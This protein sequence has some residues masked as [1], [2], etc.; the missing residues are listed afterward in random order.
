MLLL[1]PLLIRTT[2][3]RANGTFVIMAK[4][5]LSLVPGWNLVSFNLHPSDTAISTVLSGIAGKYDLVYA[6]DAT[7][8][9]SASGNWMKYDPNPRHMEITFEQ[10]GREDGLLDSHEGRGYVGSGGGLPRQRR[11]CA[12]WIMGGW[13]LVGYPSIQAGNYQAYC[14]PW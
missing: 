9:H 7:G 8:A 3:A 2:Q 5:S 10:V 14:G 6:W 11:I 12:I 4:H 1:P 13:N